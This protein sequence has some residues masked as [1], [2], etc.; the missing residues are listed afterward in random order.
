[1][2][3]SGI[4]DRTYYTQD[5]R[6]GSY[7][8]VSLDNVIDQFMTVYVG[9]DKVINKASR[10]DV[11]FFAQRALA[12]LSF[13]TLKSF[14]AFEIVVPA[15]LSMVLPRDYVNYTKLSWVDSSGIKH[16]LYST[17][18][19]SAPKK[20]NVDADGDFLF[21]SGNSLIDSGEI[22]KNGN[23]NGTL[24]YWQSFN[25][26]IDDPTVTLDANNDIQQGFSVIDNKLVCVDLPNFGR[27]IQ[28][29][30]EI[31][32]NHKYKVT[33]TI[34]NYVS[35]TVKARIV[36][37]LGHST[38]G[39]G[40][41][42]NGTYTETLTAGELTLVDGSLIKRSFRIGNYDDTALGNFTI[43][44]VSLVEVGLEDESTTSKNY[45]ANTPAE[46]N[47]DDY[48]DETYWPHEGERYGLEPEH[49]Q[50][51]GSYFIDDLRGKINFSSNL[52]GKTVILDYISDSLGTD[53]E[54]Q[55]HKFAE[56]AM[57]KWI[58]Y[59]LLSTKAGIP[60]YIVQRSKKEKFAA[61][62]QAKLRL[63]NI[64]VEEIAQILRGKSKQIKH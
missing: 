33:Y 24:D 7:Q 63:S 39:V 29:D 21:S 34:S 35:G 53:A 20:I 48:D 13:D 55:V 23:F 38:T 19:T 46:N 16:P 11:A 54:M 31:Q 62:R 15:S 59:G 43:D 1:M 14:K 26:E 61:T 42:A 64:K 49:A 60:E 32:N 52:S 40:R 8:F 41:T 58:T 36:D 6:H 50:V 10:T 45:K 9:D 28:S 12:E 3:Y 44:S 4:S 51:N 25:Q 22:I 56:E 5:Y 30:L 18:H 27:V 37:N 17:R 57:Y 47:N 2:G